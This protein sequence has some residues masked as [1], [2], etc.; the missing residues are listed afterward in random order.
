MAIMIRIIEGDEVVCVHRC[1]RER[2]IDDN[3]DINGINEKILI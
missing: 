3:V 1:T 2:I